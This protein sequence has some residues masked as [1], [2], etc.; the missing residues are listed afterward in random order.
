MLD[1]TDNK[2]GK[3]KRGIL[4]LFLLAFMFFSLSNIQ[5]A[6]PFQTGTFTNGYEIKV[7]PIIV[8]KQNTNFDFNFHV[9]NISNGL[10]IDNSSTS[11]FLHI[12]NSTGE[13]ITV[14]VPHIESNIP[15]EWEITVLGGNFSQTGVMGYSVQC[16]STTLG[17]FTTNNFLVTGSGQEVSTSA[18][19]IYILVSLFIFGMFAFFLYLGMSAEWKD[20]VDAKGNITGVSKRKYAKLLYFWIATGFFMWSVQIISL[21][22]NSYIELSSARNWI[23]SIFL[24]SGRLS[25]GITT[26]FLMLFIILVWRDMI[27][28]KHVR[29]YGKKLWREIS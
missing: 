29:T 28:S 20:E 17:G 10:P 16:N 12:Y 18:S 2:R 22:T 14:D 15:N 27:L 4:I 26:L 6:P 7:P 19:L 21:V 8:L 3:S 1:K 24:Y 13:Q 11:C 9:F 25:I 5:A 23:T